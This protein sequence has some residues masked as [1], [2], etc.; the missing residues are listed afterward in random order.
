[1]NFVA[2]QNQRTAL[3]QYLSPFNWGKM[4]DKAA[5]FMRKNKHFVAETIVILF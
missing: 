2:S 4:P 1:V 5:N 3:V